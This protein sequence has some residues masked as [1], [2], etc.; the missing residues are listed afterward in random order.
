MIYKLFS[1]ILIILNLIGT[2][3]II[4]EI[5][6]PPTIFTVQELITAGD[7]IVSN[8]LAK[9]CKIS[10]HSGVWMYNDRK[11]TMKNKRTHERNTT[12]KR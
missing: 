5:F 8:K 10:Y 7:L 12:F 6:L 1:I 9:S 11:L 2:G 4:R 3:V